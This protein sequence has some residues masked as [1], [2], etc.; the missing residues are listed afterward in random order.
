MELLH[1]TRSHSWQETHTDQIQVHKTL[2]A[3]LNFLP[4]F[5][6]PCTRSSVVA[7][8]EPNNLQRQGRWSFCCGLSQLSPDGGFCCWSISPHHSPPRSSTWTLS[9]SMWRSWTDYKHSIGK[10]HLSC[11]SS[12]ISRLLNLAVEARQKWNVTKKISN[13]IWGCKQLNMA[14]KI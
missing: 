2:K 3:A 6:V 10:A 8:M 9:C 11:S 1:S 7:C 13:S 4:V 12:D 14:K 5:I